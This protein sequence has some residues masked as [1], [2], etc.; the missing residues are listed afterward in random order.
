MYE[1]SDD[2]DSNEERLFT[3]LSLLDMVSRF[4]VLE[5]L[6]EYNYYVERD[7]GMVQ[8]VDR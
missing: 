3:L 2:Q 1:K 4:G 8:L 6:I 5:A 7:D